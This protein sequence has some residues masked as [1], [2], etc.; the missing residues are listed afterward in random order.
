MS[1][2]PR[3]S[4]VVPVFNEEATIP[5]LLRRTLGVLDRLG[6]GPHELVVVDDGSDDR[7]RA[8]LDEAARGEPRLRVVAL[9]RNFGH[10][11]AVCAG[12]DHARQGDVVVVMDGD[13]Q[14][15]P[16]AIPTL[17]EA[18]ARGHDVVYVRR[19]RR[20]EG[21]LLRLCYWLFYRLQASL[22]SVRVP[23]DAGDFA[24][25]S[26]RAAD[27]VTRLPER[28]RYV[29]GLRAWVG[30]KQV[31]I[32]VERDARRAGR[33]KYG[34]AKLLELAFDGIFAFSV[35]PLRAA[36][37]MGLLATSSSALFALYAVYARV[38]QGQSPQGFTA[39][40]VAIVFLAGVQLLFLG[41]IGE[42]VGR[43]YEEVKARP[44]YLVERLV[45]LRPGDGQERHAERQ[46]DATDQVALEPEQRGEP[47]V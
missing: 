25:L 26:R 43:I 40:I 13:L 30:F 45:N 12:L 14:D 38:V 33:T 27:A 20:K 46:A 23:L 15:P 7:T 39:L 4:V 31:G 17:L 34:P 22:S 44:V 24:L 21:A 42:Y 8:L 36:T 1:Q 47:A 3:V 32:D 2:A 10:Q 19:V 18:H 28:Q 5:E 37:V 35:V 9:S 41:V 16:E 29:R 11:A 6:G